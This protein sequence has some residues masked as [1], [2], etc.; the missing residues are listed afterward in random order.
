M[1]PNTSQAKEEASSSSGSIS[2]PISIGSGSIGEPARRRSDRDQFSLA[3]DPNSSSC[4]T[5]SVSTPPLTTSTT[6]FLKSRRPSS[7]FEHVGGML[8][9]FGRRLHSR[10]EIRDSN[11]SSKRPSSTILSV[12]NLTNLASQSSEAVSL[13]EYSPAGSSSSHRFSPL[14]IHPPSANQGFSWERSLSHSSSGGVERV[15]SPS[16]QEEGESTLSTITGQKTIQSPPFMQ[17]DRSASSISLRNEHSPAAISSP[18]ISVSS[19]NN[20]RSP[21]SLGISNQLPTTS[22]RD[23]R[24]LSVME[25]TL[26]TV[27]VDNE[28][29]S[30]V[31][32]SG[33]NSAAAIK[34]TMLSKLHIYEE[35]PS[36]F[37][38]S[39]TEIGAVGSTGPRLNDDQLLAMCWEMGDEKGTLKFLLHQIAPPTG[40]AN[41]VPPPQ[42]L[43]PH[44]ITRDLVERTSL[45]TNTTTTPT[46]AS[47]QQN[48]KAGSMSSSRSSVSEI[49][50]QNHATD[51]QTFHA[52]NTGHDSSSEAS[53]SRPQ[54]GLIRSKATNRRSQANSTSSLAEDTRNLPLT[55][56]ADDAYDHAKSTPSMSAN[57]LAKLNTS[58][59]ND[60][61]RD[62]C[63]PI[64]EVRDVLDSEE[65]RYGNHRR[66]SRPNTSQSR[67]TIHGQWESEM[68]GIPAR[69]S[70]GSSTSNSVSRPTTQRTS[71]HPPSMSES[72]VQSGLASPSSAS[73]TLPRSL[74]P[75]GGR[76]ARLSDNAAQMYVG[77]NEHDYGEYEGS[78]NNALR[79]Y[80][81]Q[82]A[83]NPSRH[84]GT[85]E[86]ASSNHH[87]LQL[88]DRSRADPMLR[89]QSVAPHGQRPS[90]SDA[91]RGGGNL[92]FGQVHLS[93]VQ[94]SHVSPP[95]AQNHLMSPVSP[96]SRPFDRER[97]SSFGAAPLPPSFRTTMAG[98]QNMNDQRAPSVGRPGPAPLLSMPRVPMHQASHGG[99]PYPLHG[100]GQNQQAIMHSQSGNQYYGSPPVRPMQIAGHFPQDRRYMSS[101]VQGNIR[102]TG[103]YL[104]HEFGARQSPYDPRM[105]AYSGNA[106]PR[107]QTMQDRRFFPQTS[108]PQLAHHQSMRGQDSPYMS[109]HFPASNPRTVNEFQRTGSTRAVLQPGMTVQESLNRSQQQSVPM[110]Y[111]PQSP[112]PGPPIRA[113]SA[114]ISMNQAASLPP[115]YAYDVR[116]QHSQ[117]HVFH[118]QQHHSQI[119]SARADQRMDIG[120]PGR[121]PASMQ[122]YFN[123]STPTMANAT[124]LPG[125]TVQQ[126]ASVTSN[127]RSSGSSFVTNNSS[128]SHA[129]FTTSSDDRRHQDGEHSAPTSARSSRS[130][131][132]KNETV[133]ADSELPY[134]AIESYESAPQMGRKTSFDEQD[135]SSIRPLP[136]PPINSRSSNSS[137]GPKDEDTFNA[138][139]WKQHIN[140]LDHDNDDEGEG[141]ARA[142]QKTKAEKRFEISPDTGDGSRSS[143]N[144]SS[145]TS[146]GTAV[147]NSDLVANLDEGEGTFKTF[148]DDDD[149]E[150]FEGGTWAQPLDSAVKSDMDHA[151]QMATE[152]SGTVVS[153]ADGTLKP[154]ALEALSVGEGLSPRRPILTLNIE[155][156]PK[157]ASPNVF[158][159]A[160]ESP[161]SASAGPGFQPTPSPGSSNLGRQASFLRGERGDWAFRPP[162][163]QLYENLDDFFPTHDLDKPVIDPNAAGSGATGTPSSPLASSPKADQGSAATSALA[164]TST[165]NVS[166]NVNEKIASPGGINSPTTASSPAR[167]KMQHKKSIRIVAQD[168]KKLLDRVEAAEQRKIG[169]TDLSRRR[170]TKLWGGKVIEVT[171]GMETAS[172]SNAPDSPT[173]TT[174]NDGQKPIFKWVKGDLIGKGT[175]GRVY[176]ALNATTGE[177]IAVKQ[178]EL[179]RTASDRED[180]R[181][182]GVV[183]ALKSEI[184]TLKDLDHPNI[185]SYLGFEETRSNL[186][187]F[188]EYVPGGSVGSCLRKHGKLDESTIKSFLQ[189]ILGGLNYLHGRGILHRD[190]KADNLLVDFNGIVKISDFGTVRKSEDIYG[191]VASMSMQGS[192]FWMAPEVLSR[193]GYSAKVDI[194]SLGCVVLEMFAGRRPWSDE[195]AVQAMFK[196]GA[197]RRAPPIPPDVRLSKAAAHFLKICFAVDPNDRPTASR[198]LEHV[199]PH[200]ETGWQFN[201]SSLYRQLHR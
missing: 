151:A 104:P 137:I 133:A 22:S 128:S 29:F 15:R 146:L 147:P 32:V 122:Y 88:P 117:Q 66:S 109:S 21:I 17:R 93:S 41:M 60:S 67:H 89:S 166:R 50:A 184:E 144:A 192:I 90:T 1:P 134:A 9:R 54:S 150:D 172:N 53:S 118:P 95:T 182:K 169:A 105:A 161:K 18:P 76:E 199:F 112:R 175:Y 78:N 48:S 143:G 30:V 84:S 110:Q 19:S 171:P 145:T 176:L 115:S 187:I 13:E 140:S 125:S 158:G 100:H 195:E 20:H 167:T 132:S 24:R 139:Q 177:M 6:S 178:V 129:R 63:S 135:L 186:S 173:S 2:T 153:M 124:K 82:S 46:S 170:S 163:E 155:S 81:S 38:L 55:A 42:N 35:D 33:L 31:D 26:I 127:D 198:L 190:L 174:S 96:L 168:R 185:V 152:A 111:H 119:P 7:V 179:P 159:N 59:Q 51:G 73:S 156:P 5:P 79:A 44:I 8:D 102:P 70:V 25:R 149:D 3:L 121:M 160:S 164:M 99:A 101:T 197:E 64:E 154:E 27:T 58:N 113:E 108:T 56:S 114:S 91:V 83:L 85:S 183:A 196:I 107:P 180:A 191:N 148:D 36:C 162:P 4:A 130:M 72:D 120:S 201:R 189:Q 181:Q 23:S 97:S 34:E 62:Q 39:Q 71:S 61:I 94:S 16:I 194:W 68:N 157:L 136:V 11:S 126:Q 65:V 45:N 52:K 138:K 200:A 77:S 116:Q 10:S 12:S 86:A 28:R 193:A 75:G 87:P 49:P 188:L 40:T 98:S 131:E 80:A 37:A 106:P 47:R 141:T 74:L 43:S 142:N 14:A 92:P 103:M 69:A 123:P 57:Q 165:A